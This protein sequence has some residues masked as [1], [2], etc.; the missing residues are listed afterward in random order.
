MP[1]KKKTSSKKKST[2][3]SIGLVERLRGDI[4]S[5]QLYPG[6]KLTEKDICDKYDVSRTPVRESLKTLETEGLIELIPN[7][8]AF[9]IGFSIGDMKDLLVLRKTY[10][11]LSVKWAIQRIY[12]DELENLEKCFEYMKFYTKQQ[13]MKKITDINGNFHNI[14]YEATHNRTLINI[15]SLY[16]YYVKHSCLTKAT[17]Q[18]ELEEI[19]L[20]HTEIYNAF[21]M[22]D[23]DAGQKSMAK[24]IDNA[25][26]RY[27]L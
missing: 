25:I 13:D 11:V 14:I 3:I 1:G 19:L 21:M 6:Q 24:H 9:V 27:M 17:E 23:V 5:E 8:G 26:G 7:R 22:Q 15:L 20:E 12:E 4:L 18:E 10:E 16:N 2:N